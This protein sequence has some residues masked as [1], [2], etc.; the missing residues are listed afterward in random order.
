[1]RAR[2]CSHLLA[3]GH[4][5]RC[6]AIR[7]QPWCRHHAPQGAAAPP[8]PLRARDRFSRLARWSGAVHR[9]PLLGPAEIPIQIYGIL[10]SL[11]EDGDGGISDRQAGRLL[12]GY[13]RRLGKVP[14]PVPGRRPAPGAS[15]PPEAGRS[16]PPHLR[17]PDSSAPVDYD[18]LFE[19]VLQQV[20]EMR[21]L[22]DRP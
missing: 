6:A 5:C 22:I 7:N 12:R 17:F 14:F 18:H 19:S 10:M 21:A 13:L 1:M 8:P 3:N 9:M 20:P 2:E 4:R 16:A 15:A 11:L